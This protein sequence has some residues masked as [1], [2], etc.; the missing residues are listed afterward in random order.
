MEKELKR[1]PIIVADDDADDRFLIGKA[2]MDSGVKAPIHYLETGQ[3]LLEH[4]T[5]ILGAS[6]P[7]N[8]SDLPCLILLDLSM[9]HLGGR[10][11]LRMIKSFSWLRKI[12]IVILSNSKNPEDVI[13]SYED[14]A[15]SFFV[16]PLDYQGLVDLMGLLKS[17][18]LQKA[19]PPFADE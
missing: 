9:P 16:K 4:L 13:G 5:G 7:E 2:M 12:P 17:Y 19:E 1:R 18:W 10:E 14:G 6:H 15:S 11:T 3:K 8:R